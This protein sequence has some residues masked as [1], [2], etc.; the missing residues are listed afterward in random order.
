[1]DGFAAEEKDVLHPMIRCIDLTQRV[2]EVFFEDLVGKSYLAL[3]C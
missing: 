3:T 2:S 1:M